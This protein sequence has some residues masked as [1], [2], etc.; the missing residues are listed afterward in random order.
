MDS[1][2][3]AP[4]LTHPVNQPTSQ[5]ASFPRRLCGYHG[6]GGLCGCNR[7]SRRV[8]GGTHTRRGIRGS[9][10]RGGS[11]NWRGGP[12]PV[13]ELAGGG[14]CAADVG[15]GRCWGDTHLREGHGLLPGH[16][17]HPRAR[18][19]VSSHRRHTRRRSRDCVPADRSNAAAHVR[20]YTPAADK[21]VCR[22]CDGT[23]S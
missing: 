13:E 1:Y 14:T 8:D 18:L 12:I 9:A 21:V 20:G 16:V 2:S 3:Q 7:R 4:K 19:V 6:S 22:G 15:E 11:E 10:C 17:V 5:P 23:S